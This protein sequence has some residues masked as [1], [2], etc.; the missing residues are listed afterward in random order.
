MLYIH[1]DPFQVKVDKSS[2][3]LSVRLTEQLVFL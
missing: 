2:Y 1:T 3:F